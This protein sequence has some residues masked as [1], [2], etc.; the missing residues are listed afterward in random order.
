[1]AGKTSSPAAMRFRTSIAVARG[2]M[3]EL[4]ITNGSIGPRWWNWSQICRIGPSSVKA[5]RC[6]GD[7]STRPGPGPRRCH[8]RVEARR[9]SPG[10]CTVPVPPSVARSATGQGVPVQDDREPSVCHPDSGCRCRSDYSPILSIRRTLPGW[11]VA[12]DDRGP[13]PIRV[14]AGGQ[15]W[16]GGNDRSHRRLPGPRGP[17]R[18]SNNPSSMPRSYRPVADHGA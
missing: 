12:I 4:S 7:S 17:A 13:E 10:P 11:N 1:M 8:C 5:S 9:S 16:L 3:A 2:S 6:C 15:R 14:D 18:M